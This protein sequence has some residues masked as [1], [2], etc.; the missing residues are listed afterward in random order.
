MSE[1]A[2]PT[3]PERH[4][5]SENFKVDS[6]ENLKPYFDNLLERDI[7][8]NNDLRTWLRDRSE[9]ESIISEDMGWR[10]IRMTTETGNE[11]Y[12]NA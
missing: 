3:R 10:Y 11:S 5:V 7:S 8:S 9:L 6:W 12:V 4:F 1:V 2:I